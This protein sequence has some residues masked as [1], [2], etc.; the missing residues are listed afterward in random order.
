[1][2]DISVSRMILSSTAPVTN[3]KRVMRLH[4]VPGASCFRSFTCSVV[5]MP[6]VGMVSYE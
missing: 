6:T 2:T 3:L 5:G 4:L 1:M